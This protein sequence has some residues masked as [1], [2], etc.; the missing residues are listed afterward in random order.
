MLRWTIFGSRPLGSSCYSWFRYTPSFLLVEDFQVTSPIYVHFELD[1][2][3]DHVFL[4]PYPLYDASCPPNWYNTANIGCWAIGTW[5]WICENGTEH[6][7]QNQLVSLHR[8]AA[9]SHSARSGWCDP[10]LERVLERYCRSEKEFYEE[11]LHNRWIILTRPN[12]TLSSVKGAFYDLPFFCKTIWSCFYVIM[13][14]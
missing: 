5:L 13:D 4:P 2:I 1:R 6:L 14:I 10:P 12:W 9:F 11:N 8:S 3:F 7:A